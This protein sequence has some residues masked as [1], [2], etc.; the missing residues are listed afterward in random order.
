MAAMPW[1]PLRDGVLPTNKHTHTHRI[2]YIFHY[3]GHF[4]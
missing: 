2:V 4:T 3:V 1:M